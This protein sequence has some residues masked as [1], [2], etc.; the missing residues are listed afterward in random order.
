[1]VLQYILDILVVALAIAGIAMGVHLG[2][3]KMFFAKFSKI[4]SAFF[5]LL[6]AKPFASLLTEHFLGAKVTEL[7]FN[8]S[9]LTELPPASSAEELLANV[10]WFVTFAANSLG[11]DLQAVA[12]KAYASG[13]GMYHTIIAD[14]TYP[15]SSF[16]SFVLCA[17]VAY[18]IIRGVLK[19]LEHFGDDIFELPVLRVINKVI[20]A[21]FGV[22]IN[23]IILWVI[24]KLLGGLMSIESIANSS[25]MSGIYPRPLRHLHQYIQYHRCQ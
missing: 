15:I 17:I 24:C 3:F 13:D 20:G 18:F 9:K 14:L 4:T 1:M 22:C 2:F 5:G 16:I 12:E 23:A 6:L 21:I 10:P 25:F 8:M 19:L 7:V 11:Y